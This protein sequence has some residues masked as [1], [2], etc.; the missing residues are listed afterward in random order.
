MVKDDIIDELIPS[1]NFSDFSDPS[2]SDFDAKIK[3]WTDTLS[4]RFRIEKRNI[5]PKNL[6]LDLKLQF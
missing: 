5:L 2:F 4:R 1:E 3:R 6:V